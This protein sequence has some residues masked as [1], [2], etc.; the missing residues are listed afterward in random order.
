VWLGIDFER[1]Y[2]PPVTVFSLVHGTL[3]SLFSLAPHLSRDLEAEAHVFLRSWLLSLLWL[4]YLALYI[5]FPYDIC[6]REHSR[7][8]G[9]LT[10][11]TSQLHR[12]QDYLD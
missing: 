10:A 9:G 4:F 3:Q 7:R 6:A 8:L 2:V 12:H 1:D 5:T 11:S